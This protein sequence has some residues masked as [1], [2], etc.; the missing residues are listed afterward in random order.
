MRLITLHLI[1]IALAGCG[2]KHSG[3]ES[4]TDSGSSSS[5]NSETVG[6]EGAWAIGYYFRPGGGSPTA[7][8]A[9][10]DVKSDHTADLVSESCGSDTKKMRTVGWEPLDEDSI[11]FVSIDGTASPFF[12]VA[13]PPGVTVTLTRTNEEHIVHVTDGKIAR[14]SVLKWEFG[15]AGE[16]GATR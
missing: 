13:P 16:Y 5:S 12:G 7:V 4:V 11:V 14:L 3:N 9:T 6:V 2:P 15:R 8:L 10:I 1:V